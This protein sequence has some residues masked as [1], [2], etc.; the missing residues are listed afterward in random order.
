MIEFLNETVLWW[1]WIIL[2]I[3]LLILEMNMGTFF[4]LGF[5]VAAILVGTLDNFMGTSFKTELFIWMV[6]SILSIAI[7]FKWFRTKLVSNSGQSNYKLD[8][9]GT[10]MEDIE[11]HSRGKVTFDTPVLG[12]TSWHATAKVNI[13]KNTRVKIVEINGQL[14]EVQPH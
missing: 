3:V 14:I 12:N 7:W 2:G 11:P 13:A 10:V 8:T 5:G 4:M 6:F 1:H 9:L